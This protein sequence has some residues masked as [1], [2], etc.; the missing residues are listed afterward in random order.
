MI[1]LEPYWSNLH[2]EIE[3]L[4]QLFH[5]AIQTV[6]EDGEKWVRE[7]VENNIFETATKAKVEM[8]ITV[9]LFG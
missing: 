4:T 8:V 5:D 2:E 3:V 6:K 9:I 1:D 7:Y